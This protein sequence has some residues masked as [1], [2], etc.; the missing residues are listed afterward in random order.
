MVWVR[1]GITIN[2]F[3]RKF[4]DILVGLWFLA[5]LLS[6][7]CQNTVGTDAPA[8]TPTPVPTLGPVRLK[9]IG[10]WDPNLILFDDM[11]GD[12]HIG[13][14]TIDQEFGTDSYY[15]WYFNPEL[16]RESRA[17]P[18]ETFAVYPTIKLASDHYADW[19][20]SRIPPDRISHWKEVPALEFP[21]HASEVKIACLPSSV[22]GQSFLHCVT[23]AQYQ[24]TI[25]VIEGNVYEGKWFT[26]D[27]YRAVLQAADRRITLILSGATP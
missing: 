3:N 12:W 6:S 23:I 26:I 14:R 24:N 2:H 20:D 8:I 19:R 27:D 11:P 17:G 4:R 5:L 13:G 16:P 10:K 18:S 15:Y 22:N 1:R 25:V 9:P 21:H 7:A